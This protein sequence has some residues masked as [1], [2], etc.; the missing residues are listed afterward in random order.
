MIHIEFMRDLLPRMSESAP[1]SAKKNTADM[2]DA[3]KS[4]S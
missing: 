2:L 1:M 4:V 3:V